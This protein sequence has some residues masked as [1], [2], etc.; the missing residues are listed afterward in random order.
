MKNTE[1]FSLDIICKSKNRKVSV[2]LTVYHALK[3]Y[4]RSGGIAPLIL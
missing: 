2:L 4:W 3:A 1:E